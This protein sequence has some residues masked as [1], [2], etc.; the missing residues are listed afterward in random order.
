MEANIFACLK[1]VGLPLGILKKVEVVMKTIIER[2]PKGLI[3]N[4]FAKNDF[5]TGFRA[6]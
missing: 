5:L 2:E 1:L 4:R 3:N 6:F